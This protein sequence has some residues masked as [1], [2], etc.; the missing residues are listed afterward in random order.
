MHVEMLL[1]TSN[2]LLLTKQDGERQVAFKHGL[3]ALVHSLTRLNGGLYYPGATV[4]IIVPSIVIWFVGYL[5]YTTC[6]KYI[7]HDSASLVSQ[8]F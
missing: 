1:K 5:Q 7:I 8:L 6:R 2:L 3:K 4:L